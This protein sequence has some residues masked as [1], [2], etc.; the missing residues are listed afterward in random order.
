MLKNEVSCCDDDFK[1]SGDDSFFDNTSDLLTFSQLSKTQKQI[2]QMDLNIKNKQLKQI[3]FTNKF[4]TSLFQKIKNSFPFIF[5][6][7]YPAEF[8]NDVFSKKY[9]SIICLEKNSKE[10]VGFSHIKINKISKS[11]EIVT[12]GVLREY[13]GQKLGT[14]ILKKVNEELL[15]NG[16]NEVSLYVQSTNTIAINMYIKN[17]FIKEKE[18]CNYYNLTNTTKEIAH[19]ENKAILMKKM[20]CD[21]EK[22]N[23]SLTKLK[24]SQKIMLICQ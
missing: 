22:L 1:Q 11:A 3:Y 24:Q 21:I 17:E 18:I 19:E 10:L 2:C 13:Q 6:I 14:L 4:D 7:T 23:E 9:Y 8:F 15:M 5:K 16:I 20:L 12:L